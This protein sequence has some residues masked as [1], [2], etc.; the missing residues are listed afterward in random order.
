MIILIILGI[1][2]VITLST[3]GGHSEAHRNGFSS[4]T[5]MRYSNRRKKKQD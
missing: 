5:V 3:T 1:L 2:I 4:N